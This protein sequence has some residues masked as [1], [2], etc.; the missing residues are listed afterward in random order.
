MDEL[1]IFLAQLLGLYFIFAGI[2]FMVR[3]KSLIPAV[4]EFGHNQALVLTL[5]LVELVAG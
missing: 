4:A 2:I 5:A 3:R 1:S